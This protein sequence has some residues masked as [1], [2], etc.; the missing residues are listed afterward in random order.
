MPQVSPLPVPLSSLFGRERELGE[1][2]ELL[3][4][5]RLV[6]ITGPGGVGKTRIALHTAEHCAALFPGG[7]AFVAL[8]ATHDPALLLPTIARALAIGERDGASLL[9]QLA[10]QLVGHPFLLV[11]DN[12]EQLLPA[13]AQIAALLERAPHLR[14]LTTSRA[15]LRLR[16]E[17][18]YPLEPLSLPP[19]AGGTTAPLTLA[20]IATYPAVQLFVDRTR[21]VLPGFAL[22]E[23][24]GAQVAAICARLDGLPLAI[25]LAAARL[26]MLDPGTLLARLD[27][28]L[29][30]LTGGPRDLPER[31]RTLRA[32]VQ[33]SYELLG[34][35]EQRLFRRLGVFTGGFSVE[36]LASICADNDEAADQ[37]PA[38]LET[39]VEH[40][41]VRRLVDAPERFGMLETLRELAVEL[42]EASVEAEQV[43]L[44]HAAYYADLVERAER[45]LFRR[46]QRR[47]YELLDH[48]RPNLAAALGWA[49]E[50]GTL[51]P[52]LRIAGG[53]WRYWWVRNELRTG[54]E[55][56]ERA[57]AAARG[58]DELETSRAFAAALR[59]AAVL[60]W[61]QTDF[62]AAER[63][64]A[65]S[66]TLWRALGDAGGIAN[67]LH[68]LGQIAVQYHEDLAAGQALYL[69]ALT[70]RH[71]VDDP[72]NL[73]RTIN[74]LGY[75]AEHRGEFQLAY[76]RYWEATRLAQAAGDVAAEAVMR[77]HAGEAL[78]RL[79]QF[80][81]AYAL[82][83]ESLHLTRANGFDHTRLEALQ[84]A[85]ELAALAGEG[86]RSTRLFAAVEQLRRR[87]GSALAP[88][89]YPRVV[90]LLKAIHD[91]LGAARFAALW[92]EGQRLD[93]DDATRYALNEQTASPAL[94]TPA[95][96]GRSLAAAALPPPTPS[97][98]QLSPRELEVLQLLAQ[99]LS[100]STIAER[101]V[102]SVNTVQTHVSSILAKLEVPNRSAATRYAL[103]HGLIA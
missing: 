31:Q 65:E 12:L 8:A 64:H 56:A 34:V 80:D 101:L 37:L 18:E 71:Q 53:L 79:G 28:R 10:E 96:A 76:E 29:P 6:T 98:E 51:L 25:E 102:L 36:A 27:R 92:A 50:H 26:R 70:Y 55:F 74:N 85:A 67:A 13:A 88:N 75:I 39:L 59:T 94:P 46:D 17:Q 19:L 93:L 68:G 3:S 32:T 78:A 60:A 43:R 2:A 48:E 11:L 91:Q 52:A 30:L 58:T 16:G 89:E 33:W 69:E 15:P 41:L 4:L 44:R 9:E 5:R 38:R 95:E 40:S 99:G 54:R 21:F 77:S 49:L 47:W 66:L 42:L 61:A 23:A 72:A 20:D 24:N 45:E 87:S 90:A 82:I 22:G 97:G 14:V 1:L 57:I 103:D 73:A 63:L 83:A 100:N 81:Q 7:V 86:E 35:P 84:S 62:V